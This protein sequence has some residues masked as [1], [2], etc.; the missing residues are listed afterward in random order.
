MTAT[1]KTLLS[2]LTALTLGASVLA[3]AAPAEAKSWK[4][5]HGGAI[6][7]GVIGGLALG[8]LAASSV[9]AAPVD[10]APSCYK[11]RQPVTNAWGD[12]LYYRS[13]RV[14]G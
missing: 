9:Y 11:V 3:S 7:A 12:V 4:Y 6:A 5:H 8:A 1:K 10:Y 2:A 13:V 14:C